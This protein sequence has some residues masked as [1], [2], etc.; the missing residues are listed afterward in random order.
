MESH[1]IWYEMCSKSKMRT[2][3]VKMKFW[4]FCLI[5]ELN[6]KWF[7]FFYEANLNETIN[8]KIST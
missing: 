6:I 1:K 8:L 4:E 2:L 5:C 7:S 3:I